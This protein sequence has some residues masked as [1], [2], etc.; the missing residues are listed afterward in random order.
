MFMV[1]N[2]IDHNLTH[3][4]ARRLQDDDLHLRQV[5]DILLADVYYTPNSHGWV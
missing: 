1:F 2:N 3:I 4:S 5:L